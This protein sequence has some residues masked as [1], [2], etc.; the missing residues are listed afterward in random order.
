MAEA[1]AQAAAPK[2]A[3]QPAAKSITLTQEE[4]EQLLRKSSSNGT[5]SISKEDLIKALEGNSMYGAAKALGKSYAAVKSAVEKYHIEYKPIVRTADGVKRSTKSFT[6]SEEEKVIINA[7]VFAL[8]NRPAKVDAI[9][10]LA[11]DC[12]KV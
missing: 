3:T 11:N 7:I 5:S 2:A 1:V 6:L 10:A 9:K 12:M 8:K 4:Y